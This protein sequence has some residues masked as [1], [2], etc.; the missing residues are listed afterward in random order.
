[1]KRLM[2]LLCSMLLVLSACSTLPTSGP[3]N[4]TRVAETGGGP[5]TF[6]AQ[7]PVDGASPEEIVQGFLTASAAGINDDFSVARQFL[8]PETSSAWI[9]LQQ[10]RVYSDSRVPNLSRTDTGAVR[11][12]VGSEAVVDSQGRFTES[13]PEAVISS[14]F[15]LGRNSEGE[16]RIVAL[17]NGVLLS[18]TLFT[19]QY[20]Q[21]PLYF[22]TPDRQF[23]VADVRWLPQSTLATNV[24]RQ[25]LAGPTQWLSD[26]VTTA[27]PSGTTLGA[28]GVT[29]NDGVIDVSLSTEALGASPSQRALMKSQLQSTLAVI[30]NISDVT[31]SVDGA[32]LEV[33]QST[34]LNSYPY[35]SMP[36]L[37]L[38]D[39]VPVELSGGTTTPLRMA[40]V[41]PAL[42]HLA[43]G[44]GESGPIVAVS[45]GSTLT[46]LPNDGS[47]P[48]SLL[49]QSEL[50]APSV[51]RYDWIWSGS[52]QANGYFNVAKADGQSIRVSVRWLTAGTVQSIHISR[53]GSRAVVVVD[54]DGRSR[55][56][57]AAVSR[58]SDGRPTRLS[59]PIEVAG[60]LEKVLDVAWMGDASIIILGNRVGATNAG[61]YPTIIGGPM[62]ALN[63]VNGA[64]SLTAGTSE[65]S[66]IVGTE[67]GGIVERSG[68]AWSALLS[69]ASSPALP[70]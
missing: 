23:A 11:L 24:T 49:Y 51:D 56:L 65:G 37:A 69:N 26:A 39:D 60:S 67:S 27:F 13:G 29:M 33:G 4:A 58:N 41:P 55:V 6:Y 57:V 35:P 46:T 45:D 17:E 25:L 20:A 38:V 28:D 47:S 64:I 14:E 53:E 34:E 63:E 9:P 42:S 54:N 61:L 62:T 2:L 44:Y 19:S 52:T 31:M 12:D 1:M 21:A 50:I 40:T 48:V 16:W 66:I 22:L 10:V 15:S 59:E 36:L 30:P 68:G 18:S 7:G 32:P 70:G 5:V 8:S 43:R 3:V